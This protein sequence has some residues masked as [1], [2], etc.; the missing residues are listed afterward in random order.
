MRKL[1]RQAA[2]S[3][4]WFSAEVLDAA[5]EITGATEIITIA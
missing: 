1:I 5:E 4:H 2:F 3:I